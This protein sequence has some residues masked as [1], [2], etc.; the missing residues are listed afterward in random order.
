MDGKTML[1]WGGSLTGLLGAGLL[2]LNAS[3]SGFGFVAFL[4]SN[5]AWIGFALSIRAYGLLMMQLGFTVTSV[6]GI[7]RWLL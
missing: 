6:V 4:I 5:L 7:A 1:E 2:A 3:I